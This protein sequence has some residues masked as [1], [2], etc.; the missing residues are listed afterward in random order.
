MLKA[1]SGIDYTDFYAFMAHIATH[2]VAALNKFV[3][4]WNTRD[5]ANVSSSFNGTQSSES[6]K[7]RH[8][9]DKNDDSG[10]QETDSDS[11][12]QLIHED[13]TERHVS[14]DCCHTLSNGKHMFQ[15]VPDFADQVVLE[16]R[17]VSSTIK[18][19][20]SSDH[21]SVQP[22]SKSSNCDNIGI[23]DVGSQSFDSKDL[24]SVTTNCLTSTSKSYHNSQVLSYL[25]LFKG[26][27]VDAGK[28]MCTKND[29]IQNNSEGPFGD[30]DDDHQCC[31]H[32][33]HT[34]PNLA[35]FDLRQVLDIVQDMQDCEEFKIIMQEQHFQEMASIP[36]TELVVQVETTITQM[37]QG[38]SLAR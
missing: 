2:R 18:K 9:R 24:C 29:N 30:D 17:H 20:H 15:S 36:P 22:Q 14:Q 1:D 5:P 31:P 32:W 10:D 16:G 28:R 27:L 13:D 6:Q 12:C 3:E 34:G 19:D 35:L 21:L 11:K 37:M 38:L 8:S 25:C 4:S 26:S 33:A 7:Q 23:H